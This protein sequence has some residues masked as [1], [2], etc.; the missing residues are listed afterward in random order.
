MAALASLPRAQREAAE[1]YYV[2]DQGVE[3][4]ARLTGRPANTI[5]SD[6]RRARAALRSALEPPA[7]PSPA[8]SNRPGA[9]DE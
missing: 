1:L 8:R 2:E 9:H 5:K 7:G 3:E 6:L 4:V